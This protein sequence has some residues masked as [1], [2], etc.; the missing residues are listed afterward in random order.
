MQFTAIPKLSALLL[1]A[2]FHDENGNEI[3]DKYFLGLPKEDYGFSSNATIPP[4]WKNA[5]FAV[6][7][8]KFA[9]V[10]SLN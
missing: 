6:N 9:Q 1:G 7:A 2:I 8:A 5:K 3:L 4:K 10:I